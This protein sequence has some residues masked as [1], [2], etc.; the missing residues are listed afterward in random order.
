MDKAQSQQAVSCIM[1]ISLNATRRIKMDNKNLEIIR[2]WAEESPS[3]AEHLKLVELEI[4]IRS[5]LEHQEKLKQAVDEFNLKCECNHS[6]DDFGYRHRKIM[7]CGIG[8]PTAF[9]ID[10]LIYTCEKQGYFGNAYLINNNI[11][12]PLKL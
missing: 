10:D 9:V 3:M 7:W 12:R 6:I 5:T 4:E 11:R 1:I 8:R 2:K